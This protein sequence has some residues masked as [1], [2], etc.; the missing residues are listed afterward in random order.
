M[1]FAV[2]NG[3]PVPDA[4]FLHLA[5]VGFWGT[6]EKRPTQTAMQYAL[7]SLEDHLLSH[8]AWADL[9]CA[10]EESETRVQQSAALL[11]KESRLFQ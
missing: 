2:R 4:K 1:D 3:Q 9:I 11:F 10:L 6:L 5:L 8:E 7:E